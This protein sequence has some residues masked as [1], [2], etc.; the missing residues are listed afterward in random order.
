MAG[1]VIILSAPSGSGKSTIISALMK[2]G[3]L[4]MQFS[5][6]AT[7]RAPRG[8]EVNGKDYHFLTDEEFRKAIAADAFLEY[9]EVYPGRFYGT[10]RSEVDRIAAAG[11]NTVMDIDVNGALR[12]KEQ[13]GSQALAIFIQPPSI[14]ELRRRLEARA[15]DS[16]DSIDARIDRARYELDQAPRFDVTVVNDNLDRAITETSRL[17]TEFI[18]K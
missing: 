13:L 7:N 9:E 10:L 2:A 15:T 3:E 1:K 16:P 17:I 14:D 5:V 11:S 4:N 8:A 12:V 18:S 6:S